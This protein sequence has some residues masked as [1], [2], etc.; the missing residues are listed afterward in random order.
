MSGSNRLPSVYIP[1]GGG[2]WHVMEDAFGDAAGYAELAAY[3]RDLGQRARKNARAILMISAHWEEEVPAVHFGEH[4]GMLYDY[5]GFPDSTYSLS[6]PAPGSP[7][8]AGRVETLLR[9]AGFTT[10]R[11]LARGY[12]HGAFV[13]GMVAFPEADIPVAQLSLVGT[14]GPDTHYAMGAALEPLRDEGV[15]IIGSGMSYHNLRGFMSGD[16]RVGPVSRRFDA[17]LS[18]AVTLPDPHARRQRLC[19]W[20]NAPDA[21]ECHPRSDH[22]VPLFVVAGAAGA[23]RGRVDHR[24]MLMGAAVSSHVFG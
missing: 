17:W 15:L 7:E 23:D 2:P 1:H 11:E 3:L 13:P 18:E 9:G 10:R 4:P 6:W 16:P 8:V 12:D 24:Q 19:A 22:L 14:L 5:Y 20:K 21:R